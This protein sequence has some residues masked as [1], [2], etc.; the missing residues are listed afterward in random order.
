LETSVL[1]L[2][3][4]YDLDQTP[5]AADQLPSAHTT[6]AHRSFGSLMG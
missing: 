3:K 1:A 4:D 6:G 2:I 5:L